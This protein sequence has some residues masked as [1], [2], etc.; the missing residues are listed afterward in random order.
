[1]LD[2]F[3]ETIEKD[4]LLQ[5]GILGMHWGVR[6]S[7]E[8]L[9][10]ARGKKKWEEDGGGHVPLG[11]VTSKGAASAAKSR[12]KFD[13]IAAKNVKALS[14]ADRKALLKRL[15]EE[16]SVKK[17]VEGNKSQVQ[18]IIENAIK[19]TGQKAATKALDTAV[20]LGLGKLSKSLDNKQVTEQALKAFYKNWKGK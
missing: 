6:R 16:A 17:Y 19:Q 18:S 8:Q 20:E 10:R 15:E 9:Q 2:Q 7:T 1:M 5:Y 12:A 11:E 14:D 4:D 13:K 3:Y